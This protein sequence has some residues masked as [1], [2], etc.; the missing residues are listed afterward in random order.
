MNRPRRA[1]PQDLSQ[2]APLIHLIAEFVRLTMRV[3]L[4]SIPPPAH[5][6]APVDLPRKARTPSK[7]AKKALERPPPGPL[8]V[9]TPPEALVLRRSYSLRET[10]GLLGKA[11]ITIRKWAKDGSLKSSKEGRRRMVMGED[12]AQKLAQSP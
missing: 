7:G 9:R 4:E 2:L 11:E 12:I 3:D 8:L 10:A 5:P 6:E 1:P